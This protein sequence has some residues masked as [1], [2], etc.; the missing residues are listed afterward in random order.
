M[1]RLL[2]PLFLVFAACSGSSEQAHPDAT[3]DC[4]KD[5]RAQAYVQGMSATS[6][7]GDELVLLSATPEPPARFDNTWSVQLL[8]PQGQPLDAA[9]L[10]IVPFMPDHGH[11]TPKPPI[12]E[13][14]AEP[15]V[16]T[17]GPFDLWMPGLWEMRF[18][19]EKASETSTLTLTLCI[20]E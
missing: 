17:M 2:I 12:P 4:T 1:T 14:T 8:D 18:S 15:G 13:K 9:T 20:E 6:A 10:A 19:I 5:P 16:H 3:P 11:G 7:N